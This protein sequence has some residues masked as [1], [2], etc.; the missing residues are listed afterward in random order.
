MKVRCIDP[1][2]I[3][4]L[5]KDKIYDVKTLDVGIITLLDRKARAQYSHKRFNLLKDNGT[6][7]YLKDF[8]DNYKSNVYN[9]KPNNKTALIFKNKKV[10]YNLI[11]NSFLISYTDKF[12]NV[13]DIIQIVSINRNSFGQM[14]IFLFNLSNHE[15]FKVYYNDIHRNFY[16]IYKYDAIN[17]LRRTKILKIKEKI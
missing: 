9:K 10:K 8:T 12:S 4:N 1:G 13:N 7:I 16:N 5:Q 2:D 15:Q 11:L 14:E 17:M 3:Q 6:E